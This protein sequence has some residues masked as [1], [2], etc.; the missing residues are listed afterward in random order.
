AASYVAPSAGAEETIAAIWRRILNLPKVGAEDN[1]FALGGHSLLAVQAH[2]EIRDALGATKLSIT[3]IFRFPTLS[4]LARHLDERPAPG[5]R[6]HIAEAT[7]ERA[8]ARADAMSRRRALR[9]ARGA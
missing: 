3:D 2:R 1:F 9:A 4:A 5:P 6:I 7:N 8:S